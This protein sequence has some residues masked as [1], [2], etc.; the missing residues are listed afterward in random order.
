M[1]GMNPTVGVGLSVFMIVRHVVLSVRAQLLDELAALK[2]LE[3]VPHV[4][5]IDGCDHDPDRSRTLRGDLRTLGIGAAASAEGAGAGPELR[6]VAA[7]VAFAEARGPESVV[8]AAPE[9]AAVSHRLRLHHFLMQLAAN[10]TVVPETLHNPDGTTETVL[11]A[12]SPDEVGR[13]C[14]GHGCH[15][16]LGCAARWRA[17][18]DFALRLFLLV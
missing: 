2:P 17:Q 12:S 13:A 16:G 10:H 11:S 9:G 7:P 1:G 15:V 3:G 4:N 8:E 6:T 18:L 14:M 5:F